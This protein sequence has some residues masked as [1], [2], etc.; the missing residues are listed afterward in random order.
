MN[1]LVIQ[2]DAS[3]DEMEM[4]ISE[5]EPLDVEQLGMIGG[6]ECVVNSI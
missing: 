3:I 4:A 6:G 2:F 1:E 5:I